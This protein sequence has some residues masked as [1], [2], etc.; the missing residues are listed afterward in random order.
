MGVR[1]WATVTMENFHFLPGHVILAQPSFLALSWVEKLGYT[2][3][4]LCF[5]NIFFYKNEKQ[6]C[7]LGKSGA[8]SALEYLKKKKTQSIQSENNIDFFPLIKL[9]FCFHQFGLFLGILRKL[10]ESITVI[11]ILREKS[12]KREGGRKEIEIS[13]RMAL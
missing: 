12:F 13:K 10:P 1:P 2:V 7:L 9:V 5:D 3:H 8:L 6:I 4:C 11:I